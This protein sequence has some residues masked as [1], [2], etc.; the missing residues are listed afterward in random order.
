MWPLLH[1]MSRLIDTLSHK[2]GIKVATPLRPTAASIWDSYKGPPD[3]HLEYICG[4]WQICG[5]IRPRQRKGLVS[6]QL[7]AGED[8]PP[9]PQEHPM[10]DL[11]M[12]AIGLGFFALTVGYAFACDRL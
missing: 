6:S 3:F 10:L 11:V 5:E 8:D 1:I 12:L 2:S 9:R 4:G 7:S